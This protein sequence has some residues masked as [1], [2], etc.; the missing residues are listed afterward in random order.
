MPLNRLAIPRCLPSCSI[1][2]LL[3]CFVNSL[4]VC[5]VLLGGYGDQLYTLLVGYSYIRNS[6]FFVVN[7]HITDLW[8]LVLITSGKR[9]FLLQTHKRVFYGRLSL[10]QVENGVSCYKLT[11]GIFA[12]ACLDT[13]RVIYFLSPFF[14]RGDILA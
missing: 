5:R 11:N 1:C 6:R 12:V 2:L 14:F 8:S 9:H 10:I 3:Y 7:L 13:R 4:A